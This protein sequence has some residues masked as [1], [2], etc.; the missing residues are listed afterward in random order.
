MDIDESMLYII[1]GLVLVVSLFIFVTYFNNNISSNKEMDNENTEDTEGNHVKSD[2][3]C[4][5]D[6]CVMVQKH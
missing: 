6:K 4:D 3:K 5:G 2:Y 1:G